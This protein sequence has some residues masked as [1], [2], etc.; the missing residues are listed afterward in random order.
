MLKSSDL[1]Y[2]CF[3]FHWQKLE[4]RTRPVHPYNDIPKHGLNKYLMVSSQISKGKKQSD[5][6]DE[7]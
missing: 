5:T 6:F 3:K 4:E 7:I 2:H 1:L